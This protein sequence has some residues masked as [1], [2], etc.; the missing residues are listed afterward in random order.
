MQAPFSG[1]AQ[2]QGK[3]GAVTVTPS[4][5]LFEWVPVGGPDHRD[6]GLGSIVIGLDDLTGLQASSATQAR[7]R[8]KIVTT[9]GPFIFELPTRANLEALTATIS[10]VSATSGK[11]SSKPGST[12]A[13][14]PGLG[15][16]KF[17]VPKKGFS[18]AELLVN[19]DL[20]QSLLKSNNEL[21]QQFLDA[22]VTQRLPAA[23]FWRMR[24]PLLRMHSLVQS[25]SRGLYNVLASIRPVSTTQADSTGTLPAR[26]QVKVSLSPDKIK[27]IFRQY[28]V[29]NRA[30]Q[31]NVP[32][33]KETE[34]WSRFF[35][36]KLCRKLRGEKLSPND[37]P[38]AALDK[39]LDLDL[40]GLTEEQREAENENTKVMRFV[41]VEGNEMDDSQKAG[42]T[43]DITMRQ[44]T[45]KD[46]LSII[47]TFNELSQRI[48]EN[49]Q[50]EAEQPEQEQEQIKTQGLA[51]Q[52]LQP[53][54]TIARV[55]LKLHRTSESLYESTATATSMPTDKTGDIGRDIMNTLPTKFLRGTIQEFLTSAI[56]KSSVIT[57][58]QIHVFDL[59]HT[60]RQHTE[61]RGQFVG[62]EDKDADVPPA[63]QA[64]VREMKLSHATAVE[65]LHHFWSAFLSGDPSR[66][67]SLPL[68]VESVEK[69][70]VRLQA[71]VERHVEAIRSEDL[72]AERLRVLK[73]IKLTLNGLDVA[74]RLYNDTLREQQAA[75][76]LDGNSA[77]N[78]PQ[79]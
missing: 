21:Q 46:A 2:Y 31:E 71:I 20:Q 38:D 29:V 4:K 23:E 34:F 59:I 66:A 49:V 52:D 44:T 24:I 67:S 63:D 12:P 62:N 43:P 35:L 22:V 57:K 73:Y 30:Y 70:K 17:A 1:P 10:S 25:Q 3:K 16:R 55:E 13:S 37:V 51:L 60:Q 79:A 68:F 69:S 26:A 41:D 48:V 5:R 54:Q 53:E 76:G 9:T 6:S 58:S 15:A 64:T 77:P 27:D 39:Y 65:F 56:P 32:P 75:M 61:Q 7:A 45:K 8:L 78:T 42:N 33:L 11:G 72:S 36:S 40:E 28:P 14:E 47:R 50:N 18:D 74:V 19:R